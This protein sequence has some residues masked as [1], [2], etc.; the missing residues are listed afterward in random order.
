[1]AAQAEPPQ[2]GSSRRHRV[3]AAALAG[4]NRAQSSRVQKPAE[5]LKDT[6]STS[7]EVQRPRYYQV[8]R[9]AAHR[10]T[11][12]QRAAQPLR[13]SSLIRAD[14]GTRLNALRSFGTLPTL[15]APKVDV[16]VQDTLAQSGPTLR[17]I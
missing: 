1:M 5:D 9:Y 15:S 11:D 16:D 4:G 12:L 7:Y 2:R 3:G 6:L 17:A 14:S 10:S 13:R 8:L